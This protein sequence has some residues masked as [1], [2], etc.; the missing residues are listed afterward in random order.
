MTLGES[1]RDL[2]KQN[3]MSQEQL[4][5]KLGVSRQSVSLWE[6]DA[7]QP[8][9]DNIITLSDIFG[10]TVDDLL[11]S[12]EAITAAEKPEQC[13][14]EPPQEKKA[15]TKKEVLLLVLD[16]AVLA[17]G[18]Y[19]TWFY[20]DGTDDFVN[21]LDLHFNSH[22]TWFA[23]RCT[24]YSAMLNLLWLG[25]ILIK[26]FKKKTSKA[27]K[28][29]IIAL[30]VV[31][32]AAINIEGARTDEAR[33]KA[34]VDEIP[35]IASFLDIRAFESIDTESEYS[36]SYV[37]GQTDS[38]IPVNYTVWQDYLS[39]TTYTRCVEFKD[40]DDEYSELEQYYSELEAKYDEDL[41]YLTDKECSELGI[42]KCGYCLNKTDNYLSLYIIKGNRVY[43]C[44][45]S[46]LD[47]INDTVKEQIKEL[48]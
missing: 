1:I 9:I 42:T 21:V 23:I 4:A 45:Y 3:N 36:E 34:A 33:E 43:Y 16:L 38:E 40:S 26:I 39:N 35:K 44:S 13:T 22:M 41:S 28:A 7:T 32:F 46:N 24:I 47:E 19:L 10:V 15:I 31:V 6:K 5:E 48:K 18:I 11:K 30:S 27:F 29:V 17:A 12:N 8:T 2:R 37:E 14:A 25:M 20:Y